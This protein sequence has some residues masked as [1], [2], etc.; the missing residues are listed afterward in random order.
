MR[1][2]EDVGV[3]QGQVEID[4]HDAVA[5][6]AGQDAAEVDRQARR[7]DAAGRAADGDHVA[8]AAAAVAGAELGGADPV[9]GARS[10]LRP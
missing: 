7:A 2:E 6:F 1:V 5:L 8:G 9:E 3:A 10:G 4:Q